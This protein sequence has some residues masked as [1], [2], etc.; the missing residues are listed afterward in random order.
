M[1]PGADIQLVQTSINL[2]SDAVNQDEANPQAVEQGEVVDMMGKAGIQNRLPAE[3]DDKGTIPMSVDIRRG[4]SEP[5]DKGLWLV[6]CIWL[7][8]GMSHGR[9]NGSA[10]GTPV[11]RIS[12]GYP[13]L[14][15]GTRS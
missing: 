13:L 15:L 9:R 2:R 5:V 10:D 14:R 8:G 12:P 3:G 11:V 6:R 7:R 1:K 4:I